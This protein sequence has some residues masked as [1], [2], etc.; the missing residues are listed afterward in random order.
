[1]GSAI[2]VPLEEYLTTSYEYDCEWVD[3]E[4]RERA[5]PDEHHS[6]IQGFLLAYF[7]AMR[8]ELGVR[9]RAELRLRVA[10]R[11]YRV[12]DLAL[13]LA[14][15]PFGGVPETPPL[16]CVEIVSPDDRMSE[17]Q[18]KI[19]DYVRMGVPSIWIVDPHKRTLFTADADGVHPVEVLA[20]AGTTVRLTG[21]EIFAELDLLEKAQ[22]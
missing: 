19:A 17:M 13:L 15:S 18:E 5:M 6:A 9:A 4:L 2:A 14:S 8:L 7:W 21:A 3:G 20:L 10:A 12:P 22:A 1:M 16:L 11:R